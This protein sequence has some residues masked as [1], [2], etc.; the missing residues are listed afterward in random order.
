[1]SRKSLDEFAVLLATTP[2]WV[3]ISKTKQAELSS[4]AEFMQWLAGFANKNGYD[5][6]PEDIED[7]NR[8]FNGK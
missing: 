8:E 2:E 6:Q 3:E 4:R 7:M 5:V 1:M